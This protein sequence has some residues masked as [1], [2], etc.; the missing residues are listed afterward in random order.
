MKCIDL[1]IGTL[2]LHINS[3]LELRLED[4]LLPFVSAAPLAGDVVRLN[5][6]GNVISVPEAAVCLGKGTMLEYFRFNDDNYAAAI[7]GTEGSAGCCRYSGNRI[8]LYLNTEK[9]PESLSG[10]GKVLRL[11]PMRELLFQSGCLL[12]HASRVKLPGREGVIL[13]TAPSGGG[14]TTQANLWRDYLGGEVLSNDRVI[15]YRSGDIWMTASSPIDGSSPIHANVNAPLRAIVFPKKAK[16][17]LVE[18]CPPHKAIAELMQQ[19]PLD[20]WNLQHRNFVLETWSGVLN[21]LPAYTL[22]ALPEESAARCL[23]S[24]LEKDGLL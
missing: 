15:V 12:L 19:T 24:Q 10:I 23:A 9:F 2:Q 4:Y 11:I 3:E 21:R 6:T 13:F 22:F 5:I 20:D 7:S 16:E 17:N 14:K 8:D 1:T 18:K